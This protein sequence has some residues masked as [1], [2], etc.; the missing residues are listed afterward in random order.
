MKQFDQQKKELLEEL[1]LQEILKHNEK[2]NLTSI[3]DIES[4][5]LLHLEDSLTGLT[6]LNNAPQGLYAD[7]G[8]GGGFPGVPLAIET[9]RVTILIDS[10]RKKMETVQSI[11]N[12][13]G[14]S[15]SIRTYCGRAEDLS[16]EMPS[17]FSAMTAR[18]VAPLPSLLELAS[19]LLCIN[20]KLICYK[21]N[22]TTEEF[23]QALGI[24]EI[25][26]LNLQSKR[27]FFLSDN[28]TH[29]TI[30]SFIK[31]K[32]PQ[33]ALPRRVGM[34]QKKPLKPVQ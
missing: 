9:G 3:R 34:A 19:P 31:E 17:Q 23:E 7:L 29:R 26:G 12:N 25:C 20:G 16:K 18:A 14:L 13:L 1:Y 32:E 8:S 4:M 28:K 27:E 24:Q 33:I 30:L 22:L 5:K 2:I 11:L 10:T 6:E 15:E 21:A